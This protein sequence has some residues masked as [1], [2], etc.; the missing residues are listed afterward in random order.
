MLIGRLLYYYTLILL[1]YTIPGSLVRRG[2]L[3]NYRF[4]T[5]WVCIAV[6]LYVGSE[7]VGHGMSLAP[8]REDG[9]GF[10]VSVWSSQGSS[11][12]LEYSG[13]GGDGAATGYQGWVFFV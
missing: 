6:C 8:Y 5:F 1:Y 13:Y 11:L 4:F 10:Y 9:G 2:E 12:V 3:G 7:R